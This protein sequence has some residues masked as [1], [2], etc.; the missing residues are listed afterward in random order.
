MSIEKRAE[1]I[2]DKISELNPKIAVTNA[3]IDRYDKEKKDIV[4]QLLDSDIEVTPDNVDEL[5]EKHESIITADLDRADK[6]VSDAKSKI[7]SVKD[8]ISAIESD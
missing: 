8:Q 4:K 3:D 7:E 6:E 5:I 2:S 1:E